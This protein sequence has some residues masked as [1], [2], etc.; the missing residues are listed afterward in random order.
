VSQSQFIGCVKNVDI[1][2]VA[3]SQT[4]AGRFAF[5]EGAECGAGAGPLCEGIDLYEPP[6]P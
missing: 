5:D 2:Q 3:A 6:T 1:D 4:E